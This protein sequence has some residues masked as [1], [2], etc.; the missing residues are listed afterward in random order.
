MCD[1]LLEFQQS[2]FSSSVGYVSH[3]N[4]TNP[5]LEERKKYVDKANRDINALESVVV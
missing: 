3:I 2:G 4:L 1:S 5:D